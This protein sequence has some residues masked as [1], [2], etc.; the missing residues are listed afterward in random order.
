MIVHVFNRAREANIANVIV[1]A[2]N[3]EI[4]E[5]IENVGGKQS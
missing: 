5:A 1:A 2:S 3:I 4:K